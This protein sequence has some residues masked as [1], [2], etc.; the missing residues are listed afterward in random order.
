MS[1]IDKRKDDTTRHD[2][3]RTAA[4]I[5]GIF[6]F[7]SVSSEGLRDWF[8]INTT[9]NLWVK[10]IDIQYS[11]DDIRRLPV[12]DNDTEGR[13]YF[14]LREILQKRERNKKEG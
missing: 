12:R 1:I 9:E 13:R 7:H 3:T 2:T 14:K 11:H 4:A 8:D 5:S 10:S 6:F